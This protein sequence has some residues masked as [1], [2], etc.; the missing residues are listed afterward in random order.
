MDSTITSIITNTDYDAIDKLLVLI[1]GGLAIPLALFF[2]EK[3]PNFARPEFIQF[4]IAIGA[5]FALCALF[6]C[7]LD[8]SGL[9][10]KALKATGAATLAYASFRV[11]AK[12]K[13]AAIIEKPPTE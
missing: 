8:A 7:G 4:A 6:H 13:N 9:I 5:A 10:D 2:R 11:Y 1:V 3:L 12:P